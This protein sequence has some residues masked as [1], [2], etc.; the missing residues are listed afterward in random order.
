MYCKT[1]LPAAIAQPLAITS[2]LLNDFNNGALSSAKE[3]DDSRKLEF[4]S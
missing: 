2:K 4:I 3:D 1:S